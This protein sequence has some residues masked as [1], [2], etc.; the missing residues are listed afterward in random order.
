MLCCISC[1]TANAAADRTDAPAPNA[2]ATVPRSLALRSRSSATDTPVL[3]R[4]EQM[5][6]DLLKASDVHPRWMVTGDTLN[7]EQRAYIKTEWKA[8]QQ[9]NKM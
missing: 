7:A 5:R 6:S 1:P 2:S 3:S 9:Q 8:L 4:I